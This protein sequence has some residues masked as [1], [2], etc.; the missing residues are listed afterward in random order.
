M[1]ECQMEVL[2][3]RGGVRQLGGPRGPQ[4]RGPGVPVR[5]VP[6]PS[7]LGVPAEGPREDPHCGGLALQHLRQGRQGEGLEKSVLTSYKVTRLV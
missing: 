4:P 2:A 3:V 1:H 7:G 5:P 6:G